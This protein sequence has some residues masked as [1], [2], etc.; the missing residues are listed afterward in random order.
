MCPLADSYVA[1]A[2]REAGSV[3]ELA[4][5]RACA[6]YTNLDTR[7]SFQPTAIETLGP[8]NDRDFLSN[9]GRKIS[10]QSGDDREAS[11]LFQR[12]SILIQRFNEILTALSRRRTNGHLSASSHSLL[13]KPLRIIDTESQTIIIM[14]VQRFNVVLLHDTFVIKDACGPIVTPALSLTFGF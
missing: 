2:A 11:F 5:V 1:A 10:L 3:A 6:K 8:I 9:L 14:S 12:L 7:Y 4:A 13:F